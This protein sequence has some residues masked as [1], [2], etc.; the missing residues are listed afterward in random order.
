MTVY[1]LKKSDNEDSENLE[2][3]LVL[4]AWFSMLRKKLEQ[5]VVVDAWNPSTWEQMQEDHEFKACLGYIVRHS[6]NNNEKEV[7]VK[8]GIKLSPP[9]INH[10]ASFS[11]KSPHFSLLNILQQNYNEVIWALKNLYNAS[12]LTSKSFKFF[13]QCLFSTR[14][15]PSLAV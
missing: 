12:F 2:M 8:F 5:D 4:Q 11:G 14:L 13:P 3:W 10:Q 7:L 9:E 15:Y 1:I 6:H